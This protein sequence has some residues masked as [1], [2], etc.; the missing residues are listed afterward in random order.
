VLGA[1]H[2]TT[3]VS[4]AAN[5]ADLV[6]LCVARERGIRARIV[7]P[8]AAARFRKTSVVDRPGGE[9]WGWRFDERGRAARAA[10]DLVVLSARGRSDQE[11]FEAANQR[12][13]AEAVA[14]AAAGRRKQAV[15]GV[16]VWEGTSRGDGDA[17]EAFAARLRAGGLPVHRVPLADR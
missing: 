14:L 15:A 1:L 12:I 8:Y 9:L 11:A 17:T 2:C 4:S 6:A 16:A 5:G 3:L 7:L 13:V 10:G